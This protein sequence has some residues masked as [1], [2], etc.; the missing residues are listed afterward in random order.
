MRDIGVYLE[1]ILQCIKKINMF[2]SGMDFETFVKDDKTFDAVVRNL[3]IIGEAMRQ[4]PDEF[5]VKHK[6][7]PWQVLCTNIL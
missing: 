3:E 1:D 5:K 4:L 2:T 7:I 6:D